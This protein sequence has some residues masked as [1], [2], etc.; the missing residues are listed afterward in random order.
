MT[1]HS[2]RLLAGVT[3]ALFCS[4]SGNAR[5]AS[6]VTVAPSGS[7]TYGISVALADDALELELTVEYDSSSFGNPVVTRGALPPGVQFDSSA[8]SSG[9]VWLRLSS[10]TP[11]RRSWQPA[12][13]RFS[14]LGGDPG[15]VTGVTARLLAVDG[16]QLPVEARVVNPEPA[17]DTAA[18]TPAST[19]GLPSAP[20]QRYRPTAMA[21]RGTAAGSGGSLR[22]VK[23]PSVLDRLRQQ[24]ID[25]P[26]ATLAG[27]FR[28]HGSG[29]VRQ[30]PAVAIS[31]GATPLRILVGPTAGSDDVPRF[32]L[33][34]ARLQSVRQERA[35]I[36]VLEAV[37]EPGT[38]QASLTVAGD[39]EAT[40]YPLLV[41][42]PLDMAG[43]DL[44][45][46]D[47]AR[48]RTGLLKGPKG[49][50]RLDEEGYRQLYRYVAA[51]LAAGGK[52]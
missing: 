15:T 34:G 31:D 47:F 19:D 12:R 18:S 44:G 17:A 7:D 11:L 23:Q 20:A 40:E 4:L 42:P 6:T 2:L 35:G 25:A 33:S 29:P 37:P 48:F 16:K 43:R 3:L 26:L 50:K 46:A 41:V 45:G 52:E 13:I 24:P 8:G 22:F 30:V 36:W 32:L 49:K 10:A 9:S 5:A 28:A 21:P 51:W 14:R 39:A 38:W 1:I 27:L